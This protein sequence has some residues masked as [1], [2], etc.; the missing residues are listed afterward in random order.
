LSEDGIGI[1]VGDLG[2]SETEALP[3]STRQGNDDD[4]HS[5]V[6]P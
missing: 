6:V 3:K 5:E 1:D 2:L 4:N